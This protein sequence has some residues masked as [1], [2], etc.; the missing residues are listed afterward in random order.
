MRYAAVIVAAGRSRRFGG[1]GSKMLA[2]FADGKTVLEKTLAGFLADPDC[3]QIVVAG[4]PEVIQWLSRHVT[5][6]KLLYCYG[7]E[8]R[9]ESVYHALLAVKEELVLVHDGARC[10]L[11]AEDLQELKK[12]VSENQGAVLGRPETDT[13]HV[14][15]PA[16]RITATL[17]RATLVRA[18]TPQGFPT[19]VLTEC[20]R[21]A[22]EGG[23]SATDDAQ[24][25]L[26][27]SELPVVCVAARHDNTKITVA[28][29]MEKGN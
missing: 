19:K 29:D 1:S 26:R 6:G 10:F 4:S 22:A 16:G 23:F 24:L 18:Q 11:D 3:T 17:D 7:G 25:I 20:H 13:V 5:A 14:V 15:S 9:Q 2:E 8:S 28:A 12:Q 27:Y 21:K